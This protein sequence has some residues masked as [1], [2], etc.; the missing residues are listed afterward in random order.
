MMR[1]LF[2][3][4]RPL[5]LL[6]AL[7]AIQAGCGVGG[8]T[9]A[10][11][12][13]GG[14]GVTAASVGAVSGIGSVIVNGITY[15]TTAAEVFVGNT[16]RGSGDA[17]VIQNLS[18]GM[19]VRVEGRLADDGSA[20]ADR[21]FFSNNL[22]GAAEGISDLDSLTKQAVILGQTV[23]MDDR[24]VFRNVDA[25]SIAVGMVLEV[26]GREDESGRIFATYVNK[27]ADSL[28]PGGLVEIKGV[29]RNLVLPLNTFKIGGLTVDYSTSDLSGL[30]QNAPESSQLLRVKGR[31]EA[32]DLL[33]AERLDL[34]EDFGSGVFDLVEFEGLITR[35]GA[36][37]E[38]DMGPYTVRVDQETAYNNLTPQDLNQGTLV[39]VRGTLTDRNILADEIFLS[40]K[41]KMESD[42][43]SI[44]LDENS[45]VLSGLESATILTTA[46][47][48]IN[49]IAQGL[50]DIRP[51]DHARVLGRRTAGAEILASM[52]VVTPSSDPV[53]LA[54]T[55]ESISEPLI[56]V[57]GIGVNTSDIPS[58]G[59]RGAGGKPVS[60][61]EF[62]GVV[63]PG[64]VVAIQGALQGG[65]VNW[66]EIL[67]ESAR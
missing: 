51:G 30:P 65:T 3:H 13:I 18:V 39:I 19:V 50:D 54:G 66:M 35:A 20:S 34:E 25:A 44:D 32:A 1:T 46:T 62:F 27:V 43:N 40:E 4:L 37:G 55:V 60:P 49:G 12:G 38:F 61:G 67:L 42:V 41:I 17:A 29:V 22:R 9:V 6:C 56:V 36:P 33:V 53:E 11:G 63:K 48:R 8:E 10:G 59:F 45:L 47:T 31:L 58:D 28:P 64:D 7:A 52:I 14:T 26:S 5:M 23:L 2:R 16:S 21:V 15:D 24:T 57:L